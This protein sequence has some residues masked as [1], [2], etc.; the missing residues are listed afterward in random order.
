MKNNPKKRARAI[1]PKSHQNE[2]NK[3]KI[4]ANPKSVKTAE[5]NKLG[6][7][8][9]TM[10]LKA[11][12][13]YLTLFYRCTIIFIGLLGESKAQG[14]DTPTAMN[15]NVQPGTIMYINLEDLY[16]NSMG[17]Q[18]PENARQYATISQ[19]ASSKTKIQMIAD[20]SLTMCQIGTVFEDYAPNRVWLVCGSTHVCYGNLTSIDS[21]S[22][23]VINKGQ[24]FALIPPRLERP[25][26]GLAYSHQLC[27]D[28][29]ALPISKK[30]ILV[31]NLIFKG[32]TAGT[33]ESKKVAQVQSYLAIFTENT[34]NSFSM[35][36][37][38]LPKRAIL[39]R[40][41]PFSVSNIAKGAMSAT[42]ATFTFAFPYEQDEQQ[43]TDSCS[44][45]V[46]L[47]HCI[48]GTQ[49]TCTPP[50]DPENYI[51]SVTPWCTYKKDNRCYPTLVT[52]K[53]LPNATVEVSL[54]V[55]S[56]NYILTEGKNG[57]PPFLSSFKYWIGPDGYRSLK[58]VPYMTAIFTQFES[59]GRD[60]FV[61]LDTFRYLYILKVPT[62]TNV[63]STLSLV[64]RITLNPTAEPGKTYSKLSVVGGTVIRREYLR[65]QNGISIAKKTKPYYKIW[66]FMEI[67][68]LSDGFFYD[69]P[70]Q[71][72][73]GEVF[74]VPPQNASEKK[75]GYFLT[76]TG[77]F[78]YNY[79]GLDS[80]IFLNFVSNQIPEVGKDGGPNFRSFVIARNQNGWLNPL[81]L[82]F[83]QKRGP[84][85]P[86]ESKIYRV[87]QD[88][89]LSIGVGSQNGLIAENPE[90]R[91]RG[92]NLSV[93]RT[94][95][96]EIDFLDN[97]T[98]KPYLIKEP[99][100]E[101]KWVKNSR[102][103]VLRTDS[104]GY[105]CLFLKKSKSSKEYSFSII[106]KVEDLKYN[107][108][109][110]VDEFLSLM[111]QNAL[112]FTINDLKQDKKSIGFIN[113]K[114]SKF[115]TI[116]LPDY[117]E[118]PGGSSTP[119]TT[120]TKH[121]LKIKLIQ[122]W[123]KNH[124]L[125]IA[126]KVD[127]S[128]TNWDLKS[129]RIMVTGI[130]INPSNQANPLKFKQYLLVKIKSKIFFKFFFNFSNF[131]S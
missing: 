50:D 13:H 109:V 123:L 124:C 127:I 40:S 126:V 31:C 80:S 7:T 99:I 119:Q 107:K 46:D 26:S 122:A 14:Q 3:K 125:M 5:G 67:H 20:S 64:K 72:V 83:T 28:F 63:N 129:L 60:W 96:L 66:S 24:C 12:H 77:S 23:L 6:K 103:G 105:I 59:L 51:K 65:G 118:D 120:P 4:A 90:I 22:T 117:I 104:Y 84:V 86:K 85:L 44:L 62:P 17:V 29:R 92:L 10:G 70:H 8:E 76:G 15:L 16:Q 78:A 131:F 93:E 79:G 87:V 58:D 27:S 57:D 94:S 42:D 38:N 73:W 11:D 18:I 49:V 21:N 114:T 37:M 106:S 108:L 82:T 35:R 115:N 100:R 34:G 95:K 9:M 2:Q 69:S 121:G 128:S 45:R 33:P 101:I 47:M 88:A 19:I 81:N 52:L 32:G 48:Y 43:R 1:Q 71:V 116:D 55:Q 91:L 111:S 97:E 112:I 25:P 53:T 89:N 56:L 74:P 75:I 102:M 98:Q 41:A 36:F 39:T 54:I 130:T 30:V 110:Q 68:P 113:P 61:V